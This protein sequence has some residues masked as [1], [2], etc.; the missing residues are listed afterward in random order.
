MPERVKK[1]KCGGWDW[2]VNFYFFWGGEITQKNLGGGGGQWK[3]VS[4]LGG[5]FKY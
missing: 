3:I 2:R 5:G 1:M 4:S